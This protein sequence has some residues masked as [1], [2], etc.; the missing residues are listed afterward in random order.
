MGDAGEGLIDAESRIQERMEDL[1]R[2]RTQMRP[3][4]RDPEQLRRAE[5]VE[6]LKLARKELEGQLA[7]TS[8]ERR[9]ATGRLSTRRR[10]AVARLR[11]GSSLRLSSW[12]PVR[13]GAARLAREA[14]RS[15]LTATTSTRSSMS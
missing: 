1:E 13:P 7:A 5:S 11:R 10:I 3:P 9:R 6:S 14:G 15:M 4:F 12:L 8:H 2:E